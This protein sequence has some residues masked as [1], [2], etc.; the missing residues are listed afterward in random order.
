MLLSQRLFQGLMGYVIALSFSAGINV[1]AQTNFSLYSDQLNNGFQNWSW[2]ANNFSSTS[3]VH[4]G[5]DAISFN[6]ATWEAISFW[7]QD[8]NPAPYAY[9]TFWANG[10]STGGQILQVYLQF[11]ASNGPSYQLSPLPTNSWKQFNLPLGTLG[12]AGITNLNRLNFQ[13]TSYGKTNSFSLDDVNLA[14]TMPSLIHV[15]VNASQTLRAADARWFG[16]NTAIWDGYFD[17][18]STSNALSELGT[19]ILRFPGGSLSDEYHWATGKSGTNTWAWGTTFNNFVHI[20]TNARVQA[21][22]TVNY[23]T[24]TPQEA[25]AWVRH[26]NVTN[27][28]N[29]KNW[30]IGNE[31]YGTWETDT[32]V[33]PHDPYTY[34]VRAAQYIAQMKTADATIKIGLPVVTGEDS[35]ANGYTSHPIYNSRTGTTHYGW[36]PVVLA[37]LKSLGVTP[38]FL[39]HHV[40]PQYQ[41]D[42]DQTLLQ[43]S[44]NWANDAADLRQQI[45]DY[46]GATGTNLELLCTENNA[47]AGNQGRQSTSIVNGLYLADSLAQLMK[48]EINAFIWWDLRNGS[49][50]AGDFNSSL[51]GWRNNGD[52]G[53][54][55]GSNMRYPTF[56]GFKLMQYFARP[57]DTVLNATSDYFLLSTFAARKANGALS[58]LV[59]NKDSTANLNA[60]ITL[61]NF[62]PWSTATVR[63]YGIAQD[64]A[65]RTNG[66]AAAQ[67]IATNSLAGA[68]TNFTTAFPPYSLTLFT[69][70]PAAPKVQTIAATGGKFIFQLQGQTGVPYQIQT[71]T[72]LIA[73][74]SNATVTL[75]GTTWNVTNNISSG[76][77]FWRA[78]WLP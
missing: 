78:V 30:E 38:D 75:S 35:S 56:Y 3:P 54:I 42:S 24:G 6:G 18:T 39:V 15:S 2:G 45:T 28:F 69:F 22:I 61:T 47:D 17:T 49:D 8:F 25:A 74:T 21:M 72:N 48:T 31:C 27:H 26:A 46:F 37:T 7:H 70:A 76:A 32:N 19:S 16:L 4:S 68:G 10:D 14:A 23:G 20:A 11:G 43:A 66:P 40:Y 13:L 60:Q 34:A 53:I 71:S 63:S 55:G 59:I 51:Y 1:K 33:N 77:K 12:V 65:T 29:F 5:A 41:N 62:F 57:G 64:E 67:D 52:L 50:T 9:L 44:A 73:W 36:T 58:L